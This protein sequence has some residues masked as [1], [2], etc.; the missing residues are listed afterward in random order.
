MKVLFHLIIAYAGSALGLFIADR[1]VK[2]V[3]VSHVWQEFLVLAALLTLANLILR[4]IL[5]FFFTPIIILSLG[6]FI[7]VINAGILFLLDFASQSI[8]INGLGSL[9][10]T[11]IIVGAIHIAAR[12]LTR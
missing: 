9:I 11:T 4:P 3:A 6:V 12:F 1:F 8:T 7:L 2:G 5:K 10:I